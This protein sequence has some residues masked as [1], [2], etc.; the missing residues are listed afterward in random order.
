MALFRNTETL[1]EEDLQADLP[2]GVKGRDVEKSTPAGS[3]WMPAGEV[4][5][6]AYNPLA[7]DRLFFG[8]QG[9]EFIG[10]EDDRHVVTFAGTRAGK[11]VSAIIPNLLTYKGSMVVMGPK[12]ENADLTARTRAEKLGQRVVILDPFEEVKP[13]LAKYR[14]KFNPLS[15]L[16]KDGKALVADSRVVADA[17][18]EDEGKGA[19]HWVESARGLI[20]AVIL[21]VVTYADYE[22]RRDLNTVRQLLMSGAT[23]KGGEGEKDLTGMDG[24][25]AEMKKNKAARGVVAGVGASFA[26]KSFNEASAILSTA[27][28]NTE[29]LDIEGIQDVVGGHDFD[30]ADLKRKKM[31]VYICL[32]AT[33][34]VDC[35]RLFRLILNMLMLAMEQEKGRPELPVIMLID[36]FH[37]LGFMKLIEVAAGLI[38]GYGLRLWTIFQDLQQL[39][40]NYKDSWETFLGNAGAIQAFGNADLTS[41]EWLSKRLG[42]TSVMADGLREISPDDRKKGVMGHGK[43]HGMA[44]LLEPA[45]LAQKFGRGDKKQRQLLLLAGEKPIVLQRALSYRD[46]PFRERLDSGDGH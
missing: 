40:A 4:K 23:V 37:S 45:E 10:V 27:R 15:I 5:K 33:R 22:G 18:T 36:E 42:Q 24:L 21:H 43:S 12:P 46:A 28:R 9:N 31:T 6:Y 41:L 38:A 29:F 19:T 26:S 35:F 30:L 11:G 39:K 3:Q 1:T 20:A 34:L 17:L 14:A 16:K 44:A 13:S 2:R 7:G 32:P 8:K 25:W